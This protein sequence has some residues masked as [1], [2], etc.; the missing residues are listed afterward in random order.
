MLL[1]LEVRPSE[2]FRCSMAAWSTRRR[3]ALAGALWLSRAAFV[4]LLAA[5]I[6]GV[7]RRCRT[8]LSK[9]GGDSPKLNLL[10]YLPVRNSVPSLFLVLLP[11]VSSKG[12]GARC[13]SPSPRPT[14]SPRARAVTEHVTVRPRRA[15]GT[16]AMA[17]FPILLAGGFT[18]YTLYQLTSSSK[19]RPPP[20]KT[21]NVYID[22]I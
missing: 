18:S 9:D 15:P 22:M 12:F 17:F 14:L 6:K 1:W 5:K 11:E 20:S 8:P 3:D 7:C 16:G 19:P 4:Y 13:R 2:P 21:C 10:C